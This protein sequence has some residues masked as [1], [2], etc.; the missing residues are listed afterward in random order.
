MEFLEY[1]M[2]GFVAYMIVTSFMG[3]RDNYRAMQ[4]R[5]QL[6]EE[7]IDPDDIDLEE[8]KN[9]EIVKHKIPY[10][11]EEINGVWYCWI[12]DPK[13]QLWFAGQHEDKDL[14]LEEVARRVESD[15]FRKFSQE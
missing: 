11:V 15:L 8:L 7:G 3:M 1:V 10:H 9:I 6:I 12:T 2:L 4:T 14:M 13:G 5:K